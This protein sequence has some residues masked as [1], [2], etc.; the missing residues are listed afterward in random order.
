MLTRREFCA[1]MVATAAMPRLHG[2]AATDMEEP[3]ATR[4]SWRPGHF[5][6][7][8]IYTGTCE[9]L[10]LIFPDSTTLLLDCGDADPA[11]F[12]AKRF[13]SGEICVPPKGLRRKGDSGEQVARYVE[14][15]NPNGRDVDWMMLSHFHGDHS[16]GFAL[17]ADT[18]RFRKAIDRGWPDYAD[19]LPYPA[20]K[21]WMGGSLH[22]MSALYRRLAERDGLEVE[23]FRV[24]AEDQ[25]RMLR[26]PDRWQGFSV[27]NL[28]GSGK[29]AM[30]D[31]SV[32]DVYGQEHSRH[33]T[34]D[35]NEN[36]MSLGCVFSYGAF[37][38]FTAGDFTA[39]DGRKGCWRGEPTDIER[40]LAMAS[41]PADVAKANHHAGWSCPLELVA[42]L[43]PRV[44]LAPVWWKMHCDKATMN[45]LSNRTAYDG[46]RILLPGMLP[47][48]RRERDAGEPYLADVP[49]AVDSPTHVVID[50]PPGGCTYK[51]AL[52]DASDG[53]MRVKGDA[54]MTFRSRLACPA[55]NASQAVSQLRNNAKTNTQAFVIA[56]RSP[57][58]VSYKQ[59][60]A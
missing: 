13:G 54:P 28:C 10:F 12:Q 2:A 60:D 58:M 35:Y 5:Q 34:C 23:K 14:R 56:E 9:S 53:E 25:L 16:D 50:V 47:P 46:E 55:A 30:P 59:F 38:F 51:V 39:S 24:G 18:L 40:I 19:P 27:F 20:G 52:L 3:V 48:G 44:W 31:G 8:M 22:R 49:A 6:I 7:H 29:I 37:R 32:F 1:G 26:D 42:A 17:A 41:P 33:A 57:E 21:G 4:R 15:V 43:R 45:R 11:S 36:A